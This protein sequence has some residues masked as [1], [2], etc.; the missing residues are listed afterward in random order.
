MPGFPAGIRETP[1]REIGGLFPSE[2][3]WRDRYP[4]IEASGY[5][6]R[7]RYHPDWKPSWTWSGKDFFATEDGQ[8]TIVRMLLWCHWRDQA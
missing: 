7:P 8:A 4:D 6:L 3:W 2:M 1:L 5:R